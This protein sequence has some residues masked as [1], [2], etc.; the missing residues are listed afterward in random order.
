MASFAF[1]HK[2]HVLEENNVIAAFRV[3]IVNKKKMY[4]EQ[5]CAGKPFFF[6]TRFLF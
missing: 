6:F 1:V 4:R 3:A 2:E 5:R